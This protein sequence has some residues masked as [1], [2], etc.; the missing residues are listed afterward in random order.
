[1]DKSTLTIEGKAWTFVGPPL[2]ILVL[3][4][5]P[6]PMWSGRTNHLFSGRNDEEVQLIDL[7]DCFNYMKQW[8]AESDYVCGYVL[9]FSTGT[10]YYDKEK[11]R[12]RLERTLP[13]KKL[14]KYFV[15]FIQRS[16]K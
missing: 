2:E 12:E 10:V 5:E 9:D 6:D 13:K 7:N 16:F 4:G 15:N 8:S 11:A 1:M 3:D 14:E